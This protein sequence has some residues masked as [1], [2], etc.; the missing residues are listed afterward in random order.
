MKLKPT[1]AVPYSAVKNGIRSTKVM[2]QDTLASLKDKMLH[3]MSEHG[4]DAM[5]P[6]VKNLCAEFDSQENPYLGIE[7]PKQQMDY[8]LNNL[9]LVPPVEIALG[10]RLDEV[11]DNVA[12]DV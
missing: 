10:S 12:K 4:V 9:M 3:V 11:Y 1:A 5:S 6:E 8:M 2:F 7:T